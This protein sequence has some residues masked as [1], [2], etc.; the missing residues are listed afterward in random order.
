MITKNTFK[1]LTLLSIF[2]SVSLL[3]NFQPDG[4][5][6]ATELFMT[7]CVT[8]KEPFLLPTTVLLPLTNFAGFL[9]L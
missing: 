9:L 7:A 2:S 3:L 4:T 8:L 5:Q 6:W 1:Q